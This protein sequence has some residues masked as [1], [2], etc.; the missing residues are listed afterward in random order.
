MDQVAYVGECKNLRRRFEMG[1]GNISPRNCYVGGQPTNCRINA[2]IA[3]YADTEIDFYVWFH[4]CQDRFRMK[5]ELIE[6]LDPSMNL[7]HATKGGRF[8]ELMDHLRF[9]VH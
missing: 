2:V 9:H 1:Y 5:N 4:P 3:A 6:W 7:G 8:S